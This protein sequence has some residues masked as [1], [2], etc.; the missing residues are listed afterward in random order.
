MLGQALHHIFA[1]FVRRTWL[2]AGVTLLVCSVFAARAVAAL[3]DASVPEPAPLP[4]T[5]PVEKAPASPQ[6]TRPDGTA[7]VERNMFCSSCAPVAGG[8]PGPTDTF[9]PDA[10]LIATSVGTEPRAT[11]VVRESQAQGS[12][13][14]DETIPGVGKLVRVG[15]TSVDLVDES[16]RKG[17]LSLIE[18]PA[19][20]RGE[21]GAAT[22]S[23]AAAEPDPYADRLRKIDD[24]TFEV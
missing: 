15:Y 20:G 8:D 17:R 6:K 3:V 13:G 22:P 21:A 2:I 9:S 23:P 10:L 11:L 1:A 14:I 19:G 24:T 18:T 16:G 7:F 12:W 4:R 5:V